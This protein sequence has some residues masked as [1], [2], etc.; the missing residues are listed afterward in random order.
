MQINCSFSCNDNTGQDTYHDLGIRDVYVY[1]GLPN[2]DSS[3]HLNFN[4]TSKI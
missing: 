1:F 4:L 2:Q 3:S